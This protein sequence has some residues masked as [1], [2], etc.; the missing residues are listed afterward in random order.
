MSGFG[1]VELA[2]ILAVVL[3]VFGSRWLP[4]AGSGL[5]RAL[6]SLNEGLFPRK[7]EDIELPDIVSPPKPGEEGER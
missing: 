5:G 3:L 7:I 6:R 2:I 1:L 4:G